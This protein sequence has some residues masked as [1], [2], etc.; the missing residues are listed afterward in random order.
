MNV[1]DKGKLEKEIWQLNNDLDL[2]STQIM[3]LKQKIED[4][5]QGSNFE[6][7]YCNIFLFKVFFLSL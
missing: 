1:D 3:D 6:A 4:S 7:I 2:C 5:D